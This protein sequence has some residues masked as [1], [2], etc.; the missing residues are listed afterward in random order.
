M[1]GVVLILASVIP[2]F[3]Q[4]SPRW[5]VSSWVNYSVGDYGTGHDTTIVYVPFTFGV[6]PIDKLSLSL[7][8]PWIYQSSEDVVVTGGGV[9]VK[10]KK[11]GGT[12]TSTRST[13]ESGLGD[14]LLRA[15]YVVWQEGDFVPEI[16][17][18]VKIKFPTADSDRGLGTGDFDETIGVDLSKRLVD[19]LF[20]F[21]TVAY[22]FVGKP[23]GTD[24]RN[25]FGWSVGPAYS[26]GPLSLFAFIEGATAISPGQSDPLELRV[27]AEYRLTRALKFS[28]AVT[29][30]LS[31]GSAD[32]GLSG[33]A[34]FRF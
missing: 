29:R 31:D 18:Y 26:I 23:S 25:S 21:V 4:D 11:D 2:A 22:T 17:P 16:E 20:G 9:A 1:I 34:I 32:W 14:L 12:A 24:F 27:G 13:S 30:G 28:G 3:A 7:T 8:V 19:R 33:G 5:F 10:K 15:S 6:R